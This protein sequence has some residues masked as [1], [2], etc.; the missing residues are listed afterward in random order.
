VIRRALILAAGR[1]ERLRPL[2][3][4]TP[5][6]LIAVGG[7]RLIEWHLERLAGC[8]V[9]EVVINTAWLAA[10]FPAALGDGSRWGLRI[11]YSAEGV[12]PLETGGG[13]LHALPRLGP[14]PFLV[15]N[16][17]IWCDLDFAKL[18]TQ[19]EGV[20]HLVLVDNPTHH[21][22]GDFS[23]GADGRLA[24]KGPG[25]L[26]YAGIGV[27][28]PAILDGWRE[29]LADHPGSTA[30]PPRFPLAPLLY[31]AARR[32]ALYGQH[33]RGAWTDAGTPQRLAELDARLHTAATS[34]RG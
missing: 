3:L 28:R 15:V 9:R 11:D 34:P 33:H 23:P 18:P 19:P 10:Q 25:A 32:G 20:A 24:G 21:P 27:F 29:V 26:T 14:E 7:K 30:E 8:G 17:D 6:P 31:A 13:I 4:T 12:E 5:K 1:G 2:T 16:G 22:Q